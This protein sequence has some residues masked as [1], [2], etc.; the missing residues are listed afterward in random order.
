MLLLLSAC[1]DYSVARSQ[2]MDAFRQDDPGGT[3]TVLWVLDNSGTMYEEQ[4]ILATHAAAFSDVLA[5]GGVDFQLA[6]TTTDSGALVGDTLGAATTG[7]TDA[8]V[9]QVLSVG[10][11]GDRNET[12]LTTAVTAAAAFADDPLEIVIYADE[13]D[14]STASVDTL[15]ADLPPSTRV[16]AIVGDLPDGCYSLDAAAD[17]GPRY[18]EAQETTGGTR[19]SICAAD[20]DAMLTR[21]AHAVLGL[22]TSFPLTQL[23]VLDSVVVNVDEAL[24][25]E[26]ERDGWRY[27]ASTNSIVFDGWAVPQPGASIVITY[28]DWKNG[29]PD[30][31]A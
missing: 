19:E 6:L 26:R 24:I 25:P 29:V 17:P 20:T 14:H 23:P 2:V 7:L 4:Q 15:L 28:W 8:F 3:V 13:D 18:I 5:S 9:A 16:N 30:T 27:D 11:N 21:V 12:G 10:T 1:S 22:Q 31:G